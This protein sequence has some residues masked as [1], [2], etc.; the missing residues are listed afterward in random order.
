MSIL[1]AV[2]AGDVKEGPKLAKKLKAQ[3]KG[4]M[5]DRQALPDYSGNAPS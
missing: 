4:S 2:G 5:N 3:H 1:V